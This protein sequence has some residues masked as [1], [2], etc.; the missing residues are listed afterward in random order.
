MQA[1]T[2]LLGILTSRALVPNFA[3]RVVCLKICR[4]FVKKSTSKVFSRRIKAVRRCCSSSTLLI[5]SDEMTHAAYNMKNLS[6][7]I[8]SEFQKSL[9][10]AP[11]PRVTA[12]RSAIDAETSAA[13]ELEVFS[14]NCEQ[15]S[16]P[17]GVP[18]FQNIFVS[19]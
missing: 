4:R 17:S 18:H 7:T 1:S 3:T 5:R 15:S 11:P 12:T 6:S 2:Y 19:R 8:E 16:M 14:I 13:R 10:T 9:L